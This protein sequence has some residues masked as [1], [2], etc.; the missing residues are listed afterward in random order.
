[1]HH[2]PIHTQIVRSRLEGTDDLR[3]WNS[4]L[5]RNHLLP[6]FS[7]SLSR[8]PLYSPLSSSFIVQSY[9]PSSV[10]VSSFVG[11]RDSG[12]SA[13]GDFEDKEFIDDNPVVGE[14]GGFSDVGGTSVTI[15]N[16]SSGGMLDDN[17]LN[18][19]RENYQRYLV[20]EDDEEDDDEDEGDDDDYYRAV[21]NDDDDDN[22]NGFHK[23][24]I[25]S[26]FSY[27]IF[28]EY[29]KNNHK[30][31]NNNNKINKNNIINNNKITPPLKLRM[32]TRPNEKF[33]AVI[34]AS[35]ASLS[36]SS[37]LSPPTNSILFRLID[38]LKKIKSLN[39]VGVASC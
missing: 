32:R 10:P 20:S 23:S 17:R 18:V 24:R 35:K 19:L 7:Q 14:N 21:E 29:N 33:D 3:S 4:P 36:S 30:I 15:S 31:N 5:S 38:T 28:P 26:L 37:A 13:R 6:S 34:L 25:G 11:N 8:F 39:K 1:M 22:K 27:K 9:D 16:R 12:V 2:H